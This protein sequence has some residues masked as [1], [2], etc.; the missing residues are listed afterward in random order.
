MVPDLMWDAE[1]S[2]S[3]SD[4]DAPV[5]MI[6]TYRSHFKPKIWICCADEALQKPKKDRT[7]DVNLSRRVVGPQAVGGYAG[8]A[9]RVV[10]EGFADHQR[11]QDTITGDLDVGRVVQLSAFAEPPRRRGSFGTLADRCHS[12]FIQI[13]AALFINT[14]EAVRGSEAEI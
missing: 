2:P 12:K 14:T 5:G 13:C 10:L 4:D 7:F 1:P 9:S 11:V 6:Q 8:V 3:E